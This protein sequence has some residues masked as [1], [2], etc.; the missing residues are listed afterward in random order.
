M[1]LYITMDSDPDGGFYSGALEVLPPIHCAQEIRVLDDFPDEDWPRLM[2]GEVPLD[3]R[4]TLDAYW[5]PFYVT[6]RT[7]WRR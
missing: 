7:I 5:L 3:D 1:K 2:R 4:G 6:G